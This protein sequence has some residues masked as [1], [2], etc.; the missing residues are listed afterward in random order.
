MRPPE[1]TSL[2]V[3]ENRR[4]NFTGSISYMSLTLLT[5]RLLNV[6]GQIATNRGL[7]K[8]NIEEEVGAGIA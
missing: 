3:T 6:L 5:Q 2:L 1:T 8:K 7:N 4:E